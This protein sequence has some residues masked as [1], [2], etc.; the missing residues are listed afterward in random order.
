MVSIGRYSQLVALSFL[1]SA[2][3]LL[4]VGREGG[5]RLLSNSKTT[6][7]TTTL[8]TNNHRALVSTAAIGLISAISFS[9]PSL[10]RGTT[11]STKFTTTTLCAATTEDST[12]NMDQRVSL[13][14]LAVDDLDRSATFYEAVGW[15]RVQSS[16][17]G[18][19]IVAF[20]LLGQTLSLYPKAK[21]AEDMGIDLPSNTDTSFFS[22]ITIGHNVAE[23]GHVQKIYDAAIAAGAKPIKEPHDIFWGGHSCYFADLDGHV[24]EV[25]HNPFSP[26]GPNGEFQWN[27]V[28]TTDAVDEK[29][30]QQQDVSTNST[31]TMQQQQDGDDNTLLDTGYLNAV[32]AAAL[33]EELMSTPGFSLEQLMELA[34]LAVAEAVYQVIPPATGEEE[35]TTT[36]KKK[37]LLVCGPGNNGGDGLVC[38]RHLTFFGYECVIVY[39]KKSKREHFIN[40]VRQCED[41]NIP[42]LDE[43]PKDMKDYDAIVDAIFGFSFSGGTIRE[44]FG[45]AITQIMDVQMTHNIP[46]ISVDVPSGWNVD[47]G[48]VAN[49]GFI[50][51]VLISLTTPK[52][53]SKSFTGRHF[54]GGRFLPPK[55]AKKYNVQVC[56]VYEEWSMV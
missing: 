6:T 1:R 31:V 56:T 17:G 27:G 21:L 32:D 42:I 35:T 28:T 54:I 4:F 46:V 30:G 9:N 52:L 8:T 19:N 24:W 44:P 14:T 50:P 18:G 10:A 16:D 26:L 47:E 29:A 5:G 38:A 37:I 48:D 7:T 15:K 20:D 51:Q 39:P 22:G 36:K 41:V 25:A 45:T 40:L 12:N 43:I 23:K 49:T 11:T 55:L 33:D 13:I 2:S 53:S 3:S 34:G